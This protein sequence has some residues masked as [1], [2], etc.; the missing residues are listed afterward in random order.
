MTWSFTIQ[1]IERQVMR[2]STEELSWWSL[3]DGLE[4]SPQPLRLFDNIERQ[5]MIVLLHG[6][7]LLVV[8]GRRTVEEPSAVHHIAGISSSA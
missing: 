4:Q 8:A 2:Y 3:L 1:N 7:T 5:I 6:G